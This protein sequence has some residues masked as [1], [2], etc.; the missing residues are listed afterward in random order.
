MKGRHLIFNLMNKVEVDSIYTFLVL[1]IILYFI[2]KKQRFK[3]TF[4][5]KLKMIIFLLFQMKKNTQNLRM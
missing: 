5:D 2:F 1:G 3:T 4:N